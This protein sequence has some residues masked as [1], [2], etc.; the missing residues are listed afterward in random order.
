M[1][2][3]TTAV[4]SL[5]AG[6]LLGL[7]ESQAASRKHVLS[8]VPDRKDWYL[9]TGPVQFKCGEEL[10][11]EGDLPK[12]LADQMDW[13]DKPKADAATSAESKSVR[14]ARIKAELEAAARA[15]AE[16]DAVAADA[17]AGGASDLDVP[18]S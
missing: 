12:S 18:Q 5:G 10:C 3:I 8:A 2:F 6:A 9:A 13:E 14:K 16:A 11:Y 1:K 15:K 17:S 7:T 4:L